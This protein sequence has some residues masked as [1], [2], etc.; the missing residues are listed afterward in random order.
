MTLIAASVAILHTSTQAASITMIALTS[1]TVV[2]KP[3][4]QGALVC[5]LPT[6][7]EI[8]PTLLLKAMDESSAESSANLADP[9]PQYLKHHSD[10]KGTKIQVSQY[11]H[12]DL[13]GQEGRVVVSNSDRLNKNSLF[14][15]ISEKKCEREAG[16]LQTLP[17]SLF[18]QG[19]SAEGCCKPAQ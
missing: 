4:L 14:V 18:V 8:T 1:L 5:Y 16:E 12:L 3:N 2:A 17:F 7:G 9:Y 13:A 15:Y 19:Y 11:L 6:G 10:W